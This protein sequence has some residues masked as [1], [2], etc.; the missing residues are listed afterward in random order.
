MVKR[1][2]LDQD[3]IIVWCDQWPSFHTDLAW[4]KDSPLIQGVALF[5][6]ILRNHI[7]IPSKN[8]L[9]FRILEDLPS[10]K[11][12][13]QWEIAVFNRRYIFK[14]LFFCC[15]IS[16]RRCRCMNLV[17]IFML[18]RGHKVMLRGHLT[19]TQEAISL[20]SF[21]RQNPMWGG[22]IRRW[23]PPKLDRMSI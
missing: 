18:F 5:G 8:T 16:F 14:W 3:Q 15:H 12:T 13:W 20:R 1:H 17:S 21:T 10:R 11:L 23:L 4:K 9:L 2:Q 22:S 19:A 7:G 6:E